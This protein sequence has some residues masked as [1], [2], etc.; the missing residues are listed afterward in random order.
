MTK[1][2]LSEEEKEKGRKIVRKLRGETEKIAT[3]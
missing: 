1:N 3:I 2:E